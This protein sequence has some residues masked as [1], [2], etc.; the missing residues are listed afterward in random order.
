ML[1]SD[2]DRVTLMTQ[3]ARVHI[4]QLNTLSETDQ[5]YAQER[6]AAGRGQ[7][8]QAAGGARSAVW[9]ED[10]ETAKTEASQRNLPI[11]ILFTGS[12]W[13]PPCMQLE[14]NVFDQREFKT[15]ADQNLVLLMVDF[16]RRK[17]LPARQQAANRALQQEH[18]I[19]GYPTMI[20]ADA[21]GK[22][23]DRFGYGGQDAKAFTQMLQG[24]L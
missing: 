15:F 19:R 5:A 16:P 20:L 9:H 1:S 24:K 3:D 4:I 11:L 18:G 8:N 13:C 14:K 22:A 17:T 12:D 23:K 2:A 10:L 21:A 6:H 7:R